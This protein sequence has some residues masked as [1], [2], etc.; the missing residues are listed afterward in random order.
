MLCR[1]VNEK[2]HRYLAGESGKREAADI[3]RH[4]ATCWECR[5][6]VAS[7]TAIEYVVSESLRDDTPYPDLSG[8][9]MSRLP[10]KTKARGRYTWAF[11]SAVALVVIAAL[12]YFGLISS[13]PRPRTD[14]AQHMSE[15]QHG[16]TSPSSILDTTGRRMKAP[17]SP[18]RQARVSTGLRPSLRKVGR[19][20]K[21]TVPVSTRLSIDVAPLADAVNSGPRMVTTVQNG[22]AITTHEYAPTTMQ[23]APLPDA[24]AIA[25]PPLGCETDSGDLARTM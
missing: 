17:H 24:E 10:V 25:R 21:R 19:T 8:L 18:G 12:T 4:L 9:V 14:L 3:R 7:L 22:D 15:K 23:E 2:L 1:E 13:Q 20:Q 6:L 5:S 11:A 16:T